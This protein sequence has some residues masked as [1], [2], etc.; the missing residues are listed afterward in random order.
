MCAHPHLLLSN[1]I[2]LQLVSSF[3][4][5]VFLWRKITE[6]PNT[7]LSK[8]RSGNSGVRRIG[9]ECKCASEVPFTGHSAI[10]QLTKRWQKEKL[11]QDQDDMRGSS[12]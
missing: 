11:V 8:I 7:W 3:P 1:I 5:V 10:A 6:M 4:N 12:C 9:N 2:M